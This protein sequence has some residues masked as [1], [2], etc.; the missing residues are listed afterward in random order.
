MQHQV[1]HEQLPN[2]ISL[3]VVPL[4][5]TATVTSMVF[6]GVGSR[7][8]SDD[9][10]GLAHFTEHMVFKGGRTYKTAQQVAQTLDAVGGEFNAFTSQEFTGF[11]TKTDASHTELGLDVLSDMV[12]HATFPAEELEKEKGVIVEE[13][14]MYEDMPMRKVGHVLMDLLFGDT[15]LGRKILGTKESVTAFTRADFEKYREMFYMG[16]MCTVALAGAIT[17]ERAKELVWKYFNELP[18]GESYTPSMAVWRTDQKVLLDKSDSEQTHLII[19]AKAFPHSDPRQPT[20]R[21]L[22]TILGSTMSSRL[23]VS[24]REQQGLCY[25][26]RSGT[27]SYRDVGFLYAS[28]GV[29]NKRFPQ[30]VEAIVK[31]FKKMRDEE[32]SPEELDRAK[33]HLLGKAAITFESSDEV[34]EYYGIQDLEEKSQETVAEYLEK[35][36]KV[37]AEDIQALAKE[38]FQNEH[39]RLAAVGPHANAASIEA[40]L[41]I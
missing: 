29:D 38:V 13:I 12:L 27:D 17:P 5:S 24:V 31:E 10:Q 40:L 19:V 34:A 20:F 4:E 11:Y 22:N 16:S 41:T 7:N 37:T 30:A 15:P 36:Q 6:M 21:L 18:Q 25:Y 8:E 35:V 33:Q 32:V 1:Y 28:A 3:I 9:Q 23:F 14:N 39:L 26:V 2:G